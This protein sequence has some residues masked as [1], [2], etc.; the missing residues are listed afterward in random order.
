LERKKE[1]KNLQ[2]IKKKGIKAGVNPDFPLL[3][4][5]KKK[6]R[7]GLGTFP[8]LKPKGKK[9]KKK[10]KRKKGPEKGKKKGRKHRNPIWM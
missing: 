5:K 2:E 6:G 10:K 8:R 3:A 9:K 4:R 7:H 1:G